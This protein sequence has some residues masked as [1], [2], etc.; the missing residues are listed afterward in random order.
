MQLAVRA[1]CAASAARGSPARRAIPARRAVPARASPP[2]KQPQSPQP[3]AAAAASSSSAPS[4][5]TNTKKSWQVPF[6]EDLDMFCYQCEQAAHGTGCTTVGV[7]G[8]TP[9]VAAL[10]DLLT[11]AIIGLASWAVLLRDQYSA[12]V[13]PADMLGLPEPDNDRATREELLVANALFACLTNVNFSA[14]RISAYI[15]DVDAATHALKEKI[16]FAAAAAGVEPPHPPSE[17]HPWL[18]PLGSPV[19]FEL[20]T[21]GVGNSSSGNISGN[22]AQLLLPPTPEN[23]LPIA[24]K[25]TLKHRRALMGTAGQNELLGLHEL[26]TYASKGACAY[27]S[28]AAKLSETSVDGQLARDLCACLSF[29]PSPQAADKQAAL[30]NAVAV[31]QVNLRVMA[32]LDAGHN[33]R[34]G[35]PSPHKVRMGPRPGK[36]ILVSG[37]DLDDLEKVLELADQQNDPP[38]YV[39]THSETLP[40]H[41]YPKLRAHRSLAGNYGGAWWKQRQELDAFAKHGVALMTTNCTLDPKPSYAASMFT[42]GEVGVDASV[43]LS[44]HDDFPRL[45]EAALAAPGFS[46]ED[47]AALGPPHYTTVGHGREFLLSAAPT[48]LNAVQEGKLTR[49]HLVGGCDGFEKSRQYFDALV[50]AIPPSAAVIT[51]G[52]HAHRIIAAHPDDDMGVVPGTEIPR[53]LMAGQ[54]SDSY[55]AVQ[56][57]MALAEALGCGVNDLPLSLTLA[58]VEQKAAAVLLSLLALG[59]KGIR[60]GPT[61]PAFL[62]PAT[63]AFLVDNFQ[64]TPVNLDDPLADLKAMVGGAA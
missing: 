39:Y 10:Q 2:R 14:D 9:E 40:A 16:F 25:A 47:V 33:A 22:N 51:L 49:L 28:H 24:E 4:T 21:H 58:H 38:I 44:G 19:F 54:C 5:S 12:G 34:F 59:V 32:A 29:L 55:G 1:R 63:V 23:L 8:K 11:T 41:G 61:L 52:C 43:H 26:T 60:L 56:V 6:T 46:E 17:E 50:D 64:L 37:H 35:A 13:L 20:K 31:G 36:A 27:A 45:I 42:T 18:E 53:L 48:I 7:C 15:A 30:A 57:A 62:D 3:P